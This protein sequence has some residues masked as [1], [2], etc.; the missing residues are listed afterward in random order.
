[1]EERLPLD[2]AQSAALL[3]ARADTAVDRHVLLRLVEAAAGDRETLIAF[4]EQL[5]VDELAG[6]RPL[7]AVLRDFLQALPPG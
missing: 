7:P 1:M 4:V 2:A 6:R 3:H 5:G